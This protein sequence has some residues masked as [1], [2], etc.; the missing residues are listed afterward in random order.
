MKIIRNVATGL[1]A[2]A[3]LDTIIDAA[4]TTTPR[5]S[6]RRTLQE[7]NQTVH[8]GSDAVDGEF[9][10]FV[11]FGDQGCGA[12]LISAH[13][14]LTAAHCLVQ[15]PPTTVRVGGTTDRGTG[16]EISVLASVSHPHYDPSA[17]S[18]QNDIAV[19]LLGRDVNNV[20]F[21]TLN[22]NTNAPVANSPVM[23]LGFGETETGEGSDTLQTIRGTNYQT[24]RDADCKAAWGDKIHQ[25]SV[26][27]VQTTVTQS[28]CRGDSGGPL[29][30]AA[31]PTLQYGIVAGGSYICS[32]GGT[33][34]DVY[35]VR[36]PSF[37]FSV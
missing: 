22:T 1:L 24:I 21:V 5:P 33:Y 9:P 15:G 8:G 11:H 25:G 29:L 28:A 6:L 17:M 10:F 14:V 4:A 37:G 30:D 27:C 2:L 36:V 31:D 19:L 12:T 35:T 34:P 3:V 7:T 23:V 13:R 20:P 26:V 18:F 16:T 32:S